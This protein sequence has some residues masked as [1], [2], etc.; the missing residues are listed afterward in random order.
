MIIVFSGREHHAKKLIP[1]VQA[2]REGGAEVS[3][4]VSNNAINIDSPLRYMAPSGEPFMHVY[5]YLDNTSSEKINAAVSSFLDFNPD[6]PGVSPFWFTYSVRE[7]VEFLTGFENLLAKKE[8]TALL[9]LHTNNFWAKGAAWM[10]QRK[11]IPVYSFQEG[12]LRD[13]DQA[14]MNKQG[15]A[16]EYVDKVFVWGPNAK[17]QY[18]KAGAKAKNLHV[19][20]PPHLDLYKN[21]KQH[22]VKDMLKNKPVVVFAPTMQEEYI[23]DIAEDAIYLSKVA[24][25]AGL[26]FIFGPHPFELKFFQPTMNKVNTTKPIDKLLLAQSKMAVFVGQ[27]S[28]I[29]LEA[30]A[31][32]ALV[33]EFQADGKEILQ[34]LSKKKAAAWATKETFATV[35]ADIIAGNILPHIDP[36]A[37]KR[38][39]EN[40]MGKMIGTAAKHIAETIIKE[41][42]S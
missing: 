37:I 29:M 35:L 22:T 30:L 34:P 1:V 24:I 42:I 41:S 16:I 13:R 27:H 26:N 33:V 4:V 32:G 10:A 12:V 3:W 17:K 20:G 40:E 14:T 15:H 25:A 23:G 19:A 8:I 31:L 28:T 21:V 11:G 36:K 9:V 18:I 38:T 7:A 2:L 6:F 39:V 5:S